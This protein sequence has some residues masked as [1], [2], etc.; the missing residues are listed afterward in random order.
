MFVHPIAA[1]HFSA[2]LTV[3]FPNPGHRSGPQPNPAHVVRVFLHENTSTPSLLTLLSV[4]PN[5][6]FFIDDLED[7]W[8]F[9]T[10][11]DFIFTR[12]MTGSIK[13]FPR[14]FKQCYE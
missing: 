14:Y 10:N 11:F 7:E 4:P 2:T 13:D 1:P 8:A 3:F 6:H 12:F 9:N 5:V